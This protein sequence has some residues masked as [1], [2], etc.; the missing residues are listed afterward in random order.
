MSAAGYRIVDE[1]V[2]GGLQRIAVNPMWPLFAFMFGGALL[3]W[4]WS[5][6]NA[7]ALGS[8]TRRR[9]LGIIL[10]G[11]AGTVALVIAAGLAAKAEVITRDHLPYVILGLVVWK[12]GISYWLYFLQSRTFE[13]Y[14]YFGGAVRNGVAG[15][16][17]AYFLRSAAVSALGGSFLAMLLF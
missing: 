7:Y 3:A 16:I 17:A 6:V 1:P 8:P 9:E 13:L 5:G 12:L 11:F 15:V 10:L 2:P 14:Q 4:S